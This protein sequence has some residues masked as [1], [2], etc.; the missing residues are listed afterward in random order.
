MADC[1]CEENRE[2]VTVCNGYWGGDLCPVR[3]LTEASSGFL[4]S[5]FFV[6][7]MNMTI[8]ADDNELG[9]FVAHRFAKRVAKWVSP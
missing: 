3:R 8:K 7:V 6:I 2:A 4:K 9:D 5:S 1:V